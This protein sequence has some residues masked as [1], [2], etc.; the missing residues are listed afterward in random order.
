[1]AAGSLHDGY[2]PGRH[3][4][5]AYGNGGFRFAEMSHRGSILMLPSGVRAWAPDDARAIDRNALRPVV[6]EGG[7]VELL[8]I[9][10]GLDIAPLPDA[11]RRWLKEA[12]I[13][14]DVMQTGAAARTYNILVAENRKVAAALVAV[15]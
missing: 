10:T 9:G 8:L 3:I 15:A 13:G 12:G 4:I 7:A 1:M 14:L 2:V 6:A 5:D 11:L